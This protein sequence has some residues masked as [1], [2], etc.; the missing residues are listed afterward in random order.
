MFE[1][2]IVCNSLF[3][4]LLTNLSYF[5]MITYPETE[6]SDRRLGVDSLTLYPVTLSNLTSHSANNSTPCGTW[7]RRFHFVSFA[8]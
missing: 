8:R 3:I 7:L 2:K 5:C 1:R 4:Q 6:F